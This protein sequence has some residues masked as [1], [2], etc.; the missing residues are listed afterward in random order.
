MELTKSAGGFYV[1]LI[2]ISSTG[3]DHG[4]LHKQHNIYHGRMYSQ[5]SSGNVILRGRFLETPRAGVISEPTNRDPR[6]INYSV[7]IFLQSLLVYATQE[8]NLRI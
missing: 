8:G 4:D 1:I 2:Q 5:G 7:F 6:G 3:L